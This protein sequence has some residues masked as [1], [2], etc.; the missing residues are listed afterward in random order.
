MEQ[1]KPENEKKFPAVGVFHVELRTKIFQKKDIKNKTLTQQN[2]ISKLSKQ[3]LDK[4]KNTINKL[5]ISR[6][7]LTPL[8]ISNQ[9]KDFYINERKEKN[10][11]KTILDINI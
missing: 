10:K 3:I 4:N 7:K 9:G 5:E 8:K 11:I 1:Y 2:T 6:T